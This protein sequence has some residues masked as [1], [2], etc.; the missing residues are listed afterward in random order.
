[1]HKKI[2]KVLRKIGNSACLEKA[3]QLEDEVDQTR[4][5]NLR[6]LSLK[7][8]DIIAIAD[9]LKHEKDTDFIKSISLSYN[10]LMGDVGATVLARSLPASIGEI[11][12]VDCGIGD[13]GGRELLNWMKTSSKLT[14]ICMEQNNFSD[15]LKI[16]FKTFKLNNPKILVV[17]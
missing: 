2:A 13:Q 8:N 17:I 9:V 1:M 6:N 15:K 5:L 10:N 12:L 14:M 3:K 16:E 4:T 11:G 7:P